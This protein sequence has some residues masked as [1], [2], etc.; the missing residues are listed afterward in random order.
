[1]HAIYTVHASIKGTV[2][3]T[4]LS[5]PL[6]FKVSS[7][8]INVGCGDR[9]KTNAIYSVPQGATDIQVT[10]AWE[11]TNNAK[12]LSQ[13]VNPVPPIVSATGFISGLD[14]NFFGNCQGGGHGALVLQGSYRLP[15][16]E[17]RGQQTLKVLDYQLNKGQNFIISVPTDPKASPDA[18]DFTIKEGNRR[19]SVHLD[20][21]NATDGSISISN[22][23]MSSTGGQ[24][25]R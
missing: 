7:G 8:Q 5:E 6:T 4:K 1:M 11:N 10:A 13:S 18:C 20:L 3:T 19:Q 9:Q 12:E 14:R 16:N 15:Q 2:H 17:A 24:Y 25:S 22:K 23:T 21:K